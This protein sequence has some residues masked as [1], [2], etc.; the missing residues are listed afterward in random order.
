MSDEEFALFEQEND[1]ILKR[2]RAGLVWT[3]IVMGAVILIFVWSFNK[4]GVSW[5]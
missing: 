1:R 5:A 3:A 2:G 4:W